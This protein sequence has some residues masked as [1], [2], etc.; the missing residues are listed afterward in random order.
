M[1]D[2]AKIEVE[3]SELVTVR[4]AMRG[5]NRLVDELVAGDRDQ[6]VLT[7]HGKMLAVVVSVDRAS[8]ARLEME[9]WKHRVFELEREREAEPLDTRRSL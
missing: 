4:D 7:R 3:N 9:T 5:L 6:V 2:D 8:A 1:A